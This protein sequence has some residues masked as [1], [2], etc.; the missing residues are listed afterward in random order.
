V[1]SRREADRVSAETFGFEA[2]ISACIPSFASLRMQDAEG[3]R[4][5][6]G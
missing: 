3:N 6:M 2:L 4:A 1:G 5:T